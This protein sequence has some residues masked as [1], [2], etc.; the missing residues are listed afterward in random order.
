MRGCPC[1]SDRQHYARSESIPRGACYYGD[2]RCK[3]EVR[4]YGE[5]QADEEAYDPTG[6]VTEEAI[7]EQRLD[8]LRAQ[9]EAPE[10]TPDRQQEHEE[11][12][13]GERQDR[14]EH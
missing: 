6:D 3:E 1:Q 4:E 13:S 8:A 9:P 2:A 7:A 5:Q 12:V 14:A 10:E 11:A